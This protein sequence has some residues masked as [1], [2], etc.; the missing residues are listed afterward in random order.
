[1][2][3]EKKRKNNKNLIYISI[4]IISI[5]LIGGICVFIGLNSLNKGNDKELDE[6]KK[7]DT[8][9]LIDLTV[10]SIDEIKN[11]IVRVTNNIKDKDKIVGSGFFISSGYLV[12]NSHVVDIEGE[13]TVIYSDGKTSKASIISN[14]IVSDV[15]ILSVEEVNAKAMNFGNTLNVKVA[16]DLYAVGYGLDL[17]GDASVTKGILSARRSMAGIEYLQTDAAI[18]NGFS[19]GPLLTKD[20]YVVGINS[21]AND[22]ATIG[23]AISS[24][25]L[26]NV[27][28]KLIENKDVTYLTSDRPVNALSSV[29]K[30]VGYDIEDLYDEWKYFHDGEKKEEHK[31]EKP[32]NNNQPVYHPSGNCNLKD[33]IVEGYELNWNR[34]DQKF[35]LYLYNDESSLKV[36]AIPEHS[37]ATYKIEG[38][39]DIDYWGD[40]ITITVTAEDPAHTKQYWINVH[41]LKPTIEGLKSISVSGGPSMNDGKKV[42]GISWSYYDNDMLHL[43]G[44][45]AALKRA[46]ASV[47]VCSVGTDC[48]G[49]NRRLINNY[50]V[51]PDDP[52][53]SSKKLPFDQIKNAI[54]EEE[55]DEGGQAKIVFDL[56]IVTKSNGT[57]YASGN[58]TINK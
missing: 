25:S 29:L 5:L 7:V 15:A 1:M 54:F 8:L 42:F 21:L 4:G 40:H 36:R 56:T 11:H 46:N 49:D 37:K 27:I 6:N 20:G 45:I 12:T 30:E 51:M 17:T 44:T 14:D 28:N 24:E 34:V 52:Y 13:I 57:H 23:M 16:E 47:Y 22:N 18:N 58:S 50:N 48:T 9:E 2:E 31:E 26:Q 3:K 33:I 41:R 35:Q 39:N 55:Y 53:E 10:N 38:Q 32:N 43:S 19:G